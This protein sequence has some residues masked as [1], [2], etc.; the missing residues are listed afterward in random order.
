MILIN[1]QNQLGL[2][3]RLLHLL[4]KMSDETVSIDKSAESWPDNTPINQLNTSN[5]QT[6]TLFVDKFTIIHCKSLYVYPP[7]QGDIFAKIHVS[8][9]KISNWTNS[10]HF[11][12]PPFFTSQEI[13]I[14]LKLISNMVLAFYQNHPGIVFANG[15]RD[16]FWNN[17]SLSNE[18]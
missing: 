16:I 2:I 10:F 13:N 14:K 6:T 9:K 1:I 18:C 8:I 4:W 17:L 11:N 5:T 3:K 15:C 12:I 7:Q